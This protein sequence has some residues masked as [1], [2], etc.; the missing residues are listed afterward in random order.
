MENFFNK[1]LAESYDVIILG[2]GPAGCAAG[3]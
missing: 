2:G 1:D 3:M